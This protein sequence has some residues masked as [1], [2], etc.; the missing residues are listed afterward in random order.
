MR[1]KIWKTWY[2]Y[3]CIAVYIYNIY[4]YYIN[5]IYYMYILYVYVYIVC[6]FSMVFPVFSGDH[7]IIPS[8]P[9]EWTML[10]HSTMI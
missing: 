4:I 7:P 5:N 10:A 9:L 2:I 3:I 8:V 6:W 1:D